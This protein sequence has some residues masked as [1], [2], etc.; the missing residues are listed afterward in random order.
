MGLPAG[1]LPGALSNMVPGTPSYWVCVLHA[2]SSGR[3]QSAGPT[4]SPQ[5]RAQATSRVFVI[6]AEIQLVTSVIPEVLGSQTTT[7]NKNPCLFS[8][9]GAGVLTAVPKPCSHQLRPTPAS[10]AS[11]GRYLKAMGRGCWPPLG[12]AELLLSQPA[13]VGASCYPSAS[14][15]E[16]ERGG[17]VPI[18]KNIYYREL[19]SAMMAGPD[20]QCGLAGGEP[21]VQTV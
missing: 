13:W 11:G 8:Q 10:L 2:A 1:T 9:E 5:F 3:D 7:A 21:T 14:S 4:P 17:W 20:G 19:A 12:P 15:G 16:T 6:M 18:Q